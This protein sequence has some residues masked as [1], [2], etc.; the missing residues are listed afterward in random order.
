MKNILTIDVE[1]WYHAV[2]Y[3][4]YN[5]WCKYEAQGRVA[6]TTRQLLSVL[7]A[8]SNHATFF[9]LGRIAELSPQLIR[10][11]DNSGHELASHGWTHRR[12]GTLSP[13]EFHSE[14]ERADRAI[15]Q[16]L[17]RPFRSQGYRAPYFTL[18][19]K[20]NWALKVMSEYGMAYDS[21]VFPIYNY[22][23]GDA[24]AERFPHHRDKILEVPIS[25]LR[26]LGMNFPFSGGFY[27][28]VLPG[29]FCRWGIR[30]LNRQNQPAVVYLH[31]RE[32][33][34]HQ[35]RMPMPLW[36]KPILYCNLHST[37][38]KFKKLLHDFSFGSIKEVLL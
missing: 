38:A 13:E 8:S 5:D 32:I 30:R 10:D 20:E 23:G 9:I 4:H 24:S 3:N 17:G 14:L 6:E 2:Q 15:S 22:L 12:L 1:D 34:P 31:P 29:W 25:T 19:S 35:P 7:S 27:L 21:S 18:G 33:D 28:R 36:Q 11:I 26:F 37:M 16:A